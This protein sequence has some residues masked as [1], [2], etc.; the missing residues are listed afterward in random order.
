MKTFFN[1]QINRRQFI[2]GTLKGIAAAAAIGTGLTGA[3][4]IQGKDIIGDSFECDPEDLQDILKIAGRKGGDLAEVFVEHC[5]RRRIH[6]MNTATHPVQLELSEGVGVRV[7]EGIQ[8]GYS[9]TDGFEKSKIKAS[10]RKAHELIHPRG[11]SQKSF[12]LPAKAERIR[13]SIF[14]IRPLNQIPDQACM[15]IVERA[16]YSAKKTSNLVESIEIQYEDAIRWIL[17]ANSRGIHRVDYQPMILMNFNILS[18]SGNKRFIGRNA[19]SHKGGFEFF[20]SPV[21][22][23]AAARAAEESV[24]MLQAKSPPT[25]VFPVIL[26]GGAGGILFHYAVGQGLKGD[27][28]MQNASDFMGRFGTLIASNKITVV[29]NGMYPKASGTSHIDDEGTQTKQTVLIDKGILKSCMT[30]FVSS[31]FLGLPLTGNGR[32]LSYQHHPQ[33]T[34]TNLYLENGEDVPEKMLADTPEGIYCRSFER[35]DSDPVSGTFKLNVREAY[36]IQNG[37]I[38]DPLHGVTLSGRGI[39]MLKRIDR[40]GTDLSIFPLFHEKEPVC[41][42]SCG[43]PTIRINALTIGSSR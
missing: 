14:S 26:E 15:K 38:T 35:G 32:R 29:D 27:A 10:A 25:G 12:S 9:Y 22:E 36:H 19:I 39:D 43:Q 5:L 37:T 40:V 13:G 28:I 6:W 31:N 30:D 2:S 17:V 3:S 23:I 41:S 7:I 24:H 34:M 20:D 18:R 21:A 8:S 16:A 42:M 4:G 11:K 33:V 1:S